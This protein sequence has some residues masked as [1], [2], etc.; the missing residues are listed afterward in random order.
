[1]T[2]GNDDELGTDGDSVRTMMMA[3]ATVAGTRR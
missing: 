2:D 3:M 1:M